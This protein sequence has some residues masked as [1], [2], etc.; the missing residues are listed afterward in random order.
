MGFRILPVV[1]NDFK[2]MS[3]LGDTVIVSETLL[4]EVTCGDELD[5]LEKELEQ[6]ASKQDDITKLGVFKNLVNNFHVHIAVLTDDIKF[7]R[8]ESINKSNIIK[9]LLN[10]INARQ[11]KVMLTNQH[12]LSQDISFNDSSHNNHVDNY[13]D[14]IS[15]YN[16]GIGG[17]D[18]ITNDF[19]AVNKS[20]PR[21]LNNLFE[22]SL[23]I[24]TLV[25]ELRQCNTVPSHL[26]TSEQNTLNTSLQD[27]MNLFATS[28]L[29]PTIDEQLLQCRIEKYNDYRTQILLN[30]NY[31][32]E[33]N[34]VSRST[35]VNERS[36]ISNSANENNVR[37]A[38]DIIIQYN[39]LNTIYQNT[40][41]NNALWKQGKTL[42]IGDSILYGIDESKLK[43]TK[44]RVFPGSSIEDIFFNI[45]PLLRKK[46]SNIILHIG[47]NNAVYDNSSQIIEKIIKLKELY[48][49]YL[50][51]NCFSHL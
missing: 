38:E 27:S 48:R 36:V 23:V 49:N 26:N 43:H 29:I 25:D 14:D 34:D 47:T 16:K 21:K 13:N 37:N 50:T 35:A 20:T 1:L 45:T 8:Q 17:V 51:V 11:N 40:I 44:V 19:N 31:D 32:N 5:I 46:P 10:I 39:E 41:D 6:I 33:L 22:T 7:L 28:L 15:N 42:I 3:T 2:A 18:V 12:P 9:D 4:S 30:N 24:T